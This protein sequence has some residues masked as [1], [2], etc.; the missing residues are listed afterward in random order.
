MECVYAPS[1]RTPRQNRVPKFPG[2]KPWHMD[3]TQFMTRG[4][5]FF[6]QRSS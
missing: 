5:Y 2:V 6:L 3:L 1:S 4:N